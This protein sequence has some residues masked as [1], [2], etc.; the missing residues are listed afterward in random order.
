MVQ[1]SSIDVAGY[2]VSR[3]GFGTMQ[4]TGPNALGDPPRP[5]HLL[6][7]LRKAIDSGVRLIDT[8]SYYGPRVANRIVAEALHPYPTEL[9]IATKIGAART[10]DGGF[11]A[12][13]EPA[14]LRTAVEENLRDLRLERL[15]L[16][17]L[18]YLPSEVPFEETVGVMTEL[19]DA[20]LIG[21]IGVS[22]VTVDQ[23]NAALSITPIASIENEARFGDQRRDE[24]LDR[25]TSL[26]IPYLAYRPLGNGS[27]LRPGSPLTAVATEA[28]LPASALALAWLLSAADNLVVIP[29]TSSHDH[30]T[31]NLA[32]AD[33]V[34]DDRL[35]R[36]IEK[37]VRP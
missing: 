30:L 23:L 19:R 12:D 32:A 21:A 5:D 17:H 29:G 9:L 14:A 24:V 18:R 7:L 25:S 2:T 36:L 26:G 31:K 37:G 34:L 10:P 20:G 8:A 22:N 4:L 33:L 6:A 11:V 16:V 3:V 28:G 35:R 1:P 27:L 15:P 13:V